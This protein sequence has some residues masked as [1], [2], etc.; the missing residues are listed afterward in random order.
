MSINKVICVFEGIPLWWS[1]VH[2]WR[3]EDPALIGGFLSA[4]NTFAIQLENH[5]VKHLVI[6]SIF[7]TL[8]KVHDIDG[9]FIAVHADMI[10]EEGDDEKSKNKLFEQFIAEILTEFTK[11]FPRGYFQKPAVSAPIFNE[12]Q[13]LIQKRMIQYNY[14]L[15]R[16][17]VNLLQVRKQELMIQQV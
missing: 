5:P 8:V 10:H 1:N 17:Q 15:N 3:E 14:L 12:I 2:N 6:G 7:W 16:F 4:I 9:L 11:R 13:E